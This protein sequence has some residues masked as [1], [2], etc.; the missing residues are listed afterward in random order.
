MKT[1]YC[2]F[3]LFLLLSIAIDVA[4]QTT[5]AQ[6][7]DKVKQKLDKVTD[8]EAD[9]KLKTNIRFLKTPEAA[10][11]VY[12]KKPDLLK[13][14]N[15]KGIS[16]VPKGT[17]NISL[18]ILLNATFQALDA[19]TDKVNN[20]VVRVIKLLPTDNN[21]NIALSTL[22][23]D[24]TKLL[25]LKAV[26]TTR[27]S[28]TN[29]LELFYTKYADYALPDKIIFS[30]NTKDYKLPKGVTFDYDDGSKKNVATTD[31]SNKGKIEISYISYKINKGLPDSIFK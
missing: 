15:E 27:E 7:L 24:E 20:V 5:A 11:K 29:E 16:L 26:T 23:I 31:K 22:Y 4:A 12:F 18:N 14:K 19:G 8:Y 3:F 6:L 30:F 2:S 9:G 1:I 13:V 10:V 21:S 28:G 17:V 25:L